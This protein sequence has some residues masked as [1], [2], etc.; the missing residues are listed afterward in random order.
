MLV[1][2]ESEDRFSDEEI[3]GNTLTLLMAGE[4]TTAHTMA[5]TTLLLA[6]RPDIQS[7]WAG[8]AIEV[9]GE[10]R[11][12]DEFE[13]AGRLLYGEAV[14]RESMR[15]RPVVPL[16]GF[17]PLIDVTISGVRIPAGTVVVTMFRHAGL[18]ESGVERATE[19]DPDRWLEEG[20]S[21]PDQKSF[22]A[23][24]GGPRFCPGRNL[25]FLEAKAG[26]ATIARNFELE[27]DLSGAAVREKTN[28]TTVPENLR[29]QLR[30]RG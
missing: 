19:L 17:E 15:L 24:G 29:I 6:Q 23:F 5:W 14:L 12:V 4:D 21:A 20:G 16:T 3:V 9:L 27:F 28:F 26:M 10:R 22:L 13:T 7:C 8:E 25:A 18:H 1:A 11:F 2:Q 30:P